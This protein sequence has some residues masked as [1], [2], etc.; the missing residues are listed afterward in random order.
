M[1]LQRVTKHLQEQHLYK[2]CLYILVECIV[3]FAKL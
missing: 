3:T 1:L 2:C